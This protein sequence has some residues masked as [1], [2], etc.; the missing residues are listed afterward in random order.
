MRKEKSKNTLTG[1]ISNQ[2]P[3]N[4]VGVAWHA[5]QENS[6]L[7]LHHGITLISLIIT[8]II[9]LILAGVGLNFIIGNNGIFNLAQTAKQKYENSAEKEEAELAKVNE[10]IANG[11]ETVV[12]SKEEYEALKPKSIKQDSLI[13][14]SANTSKSLQNI[15]LNSFTNTFSDNFEEYFLYN[16]N[17]GELTCKKAGWY[18]INQNVEITHTG[19]W[20]CINF[21]LYINDINVSHC[22]AKAFS[23]AN[24]QS[25]SSSM[26]IFLNSGDRVKV[27]KEVTDDSPNWGASANIKIFKL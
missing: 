15:N 7:L 23:G 20:S 18:M 17:T 24:G 16:S 2:N 19:N 26:T 10:Y 4:N 25:N 21:Y 27:T 12:I 9:L 6:M 13:L 8:I 11:R 22:R 14:S 3:N 1:H 5:T